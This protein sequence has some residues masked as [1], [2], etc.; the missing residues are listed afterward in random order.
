MKALSALSWCLLFSCS[1]FAQAAMSDLPI[2]NIVPNP[3]FERYASSP[4]GWFYKGK[5][6]THV[7]KYW[8]S[9]TAASPDVF[10]PKVRVPTH[11]A[12][13]GF[14]EQN[15]HQGQSMV[16]LTAYGCENGKPHCREYIQIQL[17]EPLVVGQSYYAEFWVAPLERG[18]RINNLAMYFSEGAI[19]LPVAAPI[20]VIPQV[21][22]EQIV[23][24]QGQTW[25]RVAGRF[26]AEREAE[27]L[28]IGN[29]CP[30]SLTLVHSA[31]S[32]SLNYAYYYI[33]D[34]LIKKEEPILEVPIKADDLTRITIEEGKVVPLKNIFFDS[35]K[36]ELLP[37]SY[38]ELNKLLQLL[39]KNPTMIIE[40]SG[41]TDSIGDFDYNLF[42]SQRR[43]KAVVD[44][45]I[46]QGISPS[47]TLY[48][49]YGSTKAISSNNTEVGRQLNR[50]VEFLIVRK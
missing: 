20:E 31:H 5:H 27:Y 18:L 13:K 34:V 9:A 1:V 30:D 32:N 48:K 33:D 36:S 3:G 4:I 8:H 26:K 6:F 16:G 22:A 29:F 2:E 42:L 38:V 21:W 17:K 41:H 24:P 15:A 37:R 19:K 47:R 40:I 25:H 28:T 10:G 50:R 39:H 12:S 45:L 35:D 46:Q 44:F 43:A 11:W 49:G 7:M 14:G 23:G